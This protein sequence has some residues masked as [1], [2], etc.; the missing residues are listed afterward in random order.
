M[1]R[2]GLVVMLTLSGCHDW[3]KLAQGCTLE[4]G[5]IS[6]TGTG[7]A[8]EPTEPAPPTAV[9][10]EGGVREAR[11]QWLAPANTGGREITEYTVESSDAGRP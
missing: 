3:D 8:G 2:I 4:N 11:V 6:P 9:L 5:C 7:G 10:A 1:K